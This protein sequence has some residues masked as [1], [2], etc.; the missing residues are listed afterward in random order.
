MPRRH[1]DPHAT[2]GSP[3][4]RGNNPS[5]PKNATPKNGG[6]AVA[7]PVAEEHPRRPLGRTRRGATPCPRARLGPGASDARR[8]TA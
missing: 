1:P 7:A 5:T 2:K 4:N 6:S 3:C 8:A